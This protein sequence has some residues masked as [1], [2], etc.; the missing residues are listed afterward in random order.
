MKYLSIIIFLMLFS[1]STTIKNSEKKFESG[2][3]IPIVGNFQHSYQF[4]SV[5]FE[6]LGKYKEE[7][8]KINDQGTKYR[9]FINVAG[10]YWFLSFEKK[11]RGGFIKVYQPASMFFN[12]IKNCFYI[13]DYTY[14]MNNDEWDEFEKVVLS[15]G[16]WEKEIVND[17][18]NE[19]LYLI[20]GIKK[21]NY[22]AIVVSEN[23]GIDFGQEV[24]DSLEKSDQLSLPHYFIQMVIKNFY[25]KKAVIEKYPIWTGT[26][27]DVSTKLCK[28]K[29]SEPS[30]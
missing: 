23:K 18:S 19:R 1:C 7:P 21:G 14:E 16:F 9:M 22:K 25:S 20:E 6:M 30:K 26:G 12:N 27:E 28:E 11:E 29:F 8:F 24:Y 2:Y 4:A 5:S 17:F 10:M 13:S 15:D 3:I